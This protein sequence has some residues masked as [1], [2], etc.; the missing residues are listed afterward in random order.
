MLTETI[1]T[2]RFPFSGGSV[3]NFVNQISPLCGLVIRNLIVLE[4][5]T[6]LGQFSPSSFFFSLFVAQVV[7][8]SGDIRFDDCQLLFTLLCKEKFIEHGRLGFGLQPVCFL[9]KVGQ[10]LGRECKGSAHF[11]SS[12]DPLHI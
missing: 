4:G 1:T 3:G 6:L 7:V 11:S 10:A 12:I 9:L 2:G 5:K 8:V